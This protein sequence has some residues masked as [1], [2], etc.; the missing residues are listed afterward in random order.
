MES[1]AIDTNG[2]DLNISMLPFMERDTNVFPYYNDPNYQ[3][4]KHST[5][6]RITQRLVD[7]SCHCCTE[8]CIGSIVLQ[9]SG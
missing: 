6:Q 5:A 8:N 1:D 4:R 7:V 3:C 9:V 2:D